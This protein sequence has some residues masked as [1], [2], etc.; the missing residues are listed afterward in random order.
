MRKE[1]WN[2][3][4]TPPH[5]HINFRLHWLNSKNIE[6]RNNINPF[7]KQRISHLVLWGQYCPDTKVR[8]RHHKKFNYRPTALMEI[9]A[10]IIQ[11]I[12]AHQIQQHITKKLCTKVK[13][14]LPRTDWL[15]IQRSI[16]VT[17]HI[18]KIKNKNHDY[19][20]WHRKNIWQN[21]TPSNN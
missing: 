19:L 15:K 14:E 18:N 7:R 6:G 2:L 9:D 17:Y 3:L 10:K 11:K 4:N 5:T 13:Q 1:F 21:S 8:Q 12:L 20:N 16:N